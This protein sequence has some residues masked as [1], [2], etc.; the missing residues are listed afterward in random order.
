MEFRLS[1]QFGP[2][3]INEFDLHTIAF[4]AVNPMKFLNQ[5]RPS[6]LCFHKGPRFGQIAER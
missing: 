6:G 5:P 4:L 3:R 2:F 1:F